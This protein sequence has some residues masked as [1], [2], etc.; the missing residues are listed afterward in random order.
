MRPPIPS[1]L[2]TSLVSAA[3]APVPGFFASSLVATQVPPV[4]M[5]SPSVSPVH[6]PSS[7]GRRQASNI[8][9]DRSPDLNPTFISEQASPE[10]SDHGDVPGANPTVTM[11]NRMV[12]ADWMVVALLECKKVEYDEVENAIGRE[13][14]VSSDAKWRRIQLLMREKSVNAYITQLRNKW[15]STI[16]SYKKLLDSF[17]G[18]RPSINPPYIAKSLND[19]NVGVNLNVIVDPHEQPLPDLEAES[20]RPM[21]NGASASTICHNSGVKRKNANGKA[22]TLLSNSITTF[23]TNMLELEKKKDE[24]EE[25]R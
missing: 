10:E 6:P 14:I 20:Q 22:A 7:G 21:E 9:Q 5:S 25:K 13:A 8:P 23:T 1:A 3:P 16:V 19:P 4:L 24:R 11:R 2:M 17:Y 15:E 18:H 12:W